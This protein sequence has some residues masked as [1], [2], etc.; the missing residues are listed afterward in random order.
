MRQAQY[1]N[2]HGKRIPIP[3][4]DSG[5]YAN[6]AAVTNAKGQSAQ[7]GTPVRYG[8]VIYS[9][10][11]VQQVELTK[12]GPRGTT[13]LTYSESEN[14]RSKHYGDQT[15]LFSRGGWIPITFS[16]KQIAKAAKSRI[17]VRGG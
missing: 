4:C 11:T 6:I 9:S 3:G 17:V 13:I 14:P 12:R 16:A 7:Q 15:R 1:V 2:R 5:C 10:S 8:Q